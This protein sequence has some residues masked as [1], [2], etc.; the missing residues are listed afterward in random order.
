VDV[1]LSNSAD[2]QNF[3]GNKIFALGD[4]NNDKL[5]DIVTVSEDQKSFQPW[6]FD[7]QKFKEAGAPIKVSEGFTITSVYIGKDA[8]DAE[9]GR[10]QNLYV[11]VQDQN[12]TFVKTYVPVAS[13]GAQEWQESASLKPIEIQHNSQPFFFDIN[14]DRK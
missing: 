7:N 2:T 12:Q 5:N 6:T 10:R 3:Q 14:G 4:L 1:G 9:N 13:N 11:T 8:K